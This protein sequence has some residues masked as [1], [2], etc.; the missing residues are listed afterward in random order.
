M[1]VMT[2]INIILQFLQGQTID[3][4]PA[5]VIHVNIPQLPIVTVN[6]ESLMYYLRQNLKVFLSSPKY[7]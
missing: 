1:F 6:G 2:P 4:Q 7:L 3:D 5:E